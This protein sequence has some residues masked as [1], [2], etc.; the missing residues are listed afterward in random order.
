MESVRLAGFGVFGYLLSASLLLYG[1]SSVLL[2]RLFLPERYVEFSFQIFY[3]VL[4]GAVLCVLIHALEGRRKRFPLVL[5]LFMALA[6]LRTYHTGIYDYSGS[7]SLCRFLQGTPKNTLVAGHPELMDNVVTFAA[8]K[9]F[10]TYE[11]SHTWYTGYWHI[12]RKRTFDFFEAYYSSDPQVIREFCSRNRIDYL[13][14][15]DE[16]FGPESPG[17]GRVYFAPFDDTIDELKRST[18]D[19]AIL[20]AALFPPAFQDGGIRAIW[21]KDGEADGSAP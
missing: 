4:V 2:M 14:V 7:A 1:V 18:R 15:R 10:L 13:V 19:H 12:I 17:E 21:M 16:D 9:A 8:R 20:N 11:L 3:C 5:F 6:G